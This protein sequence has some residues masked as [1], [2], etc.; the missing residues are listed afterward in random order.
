MN[1]GK[2][3]WSAFQHLKKAEMLTAPNIYLEQ[4]TH[5][6]ESKTPENLFCERR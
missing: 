3:S 1:G 5:C 6:W 2:Q 4:Q